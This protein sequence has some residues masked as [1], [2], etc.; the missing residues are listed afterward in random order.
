MAIQTDSVASCVFAK[1][2]LGVGTLG[3]RE[4]PEGECATR[5]FVGAGIGSG[6]GL[7]RVG[8]EDE[9]QGRRKG[10][11]QGARYGGG[12]MG[13]VSGSRLVGRLG[14]GGAGDWR[15]ATGDWRLSG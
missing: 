6:W 4:G 12:R 1:R 9:E 2:L 14:G 5:P 8:S 3:E 7:A 11:R 10:G 13:R 15:L